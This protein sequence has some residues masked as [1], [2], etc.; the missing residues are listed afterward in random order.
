PGNKY[1]KGATMLHMIRKIFDNDER[2][3][4]MLHA[5]SA[6][7]YHKTVTGAQVE[8]HISMHAGRDLSKVFDQYLRDTTLPELQ[9]RIVGQVLYFR[10]SSSIKNFD[11]PVK[12]TVGI[13]N[14]QFI[15]PGPLWATANL[16]YMDP[17][18]FKVD[19]DFY[20][21]VREMKTVK[22]MKEALKKQ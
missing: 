6:D 13:N 19:P 22:E 8:R 16:S 3:R 12:V 7:Y 20:I 9:Y 4:M 18:Y 17:K 5:L 21:K 15:Y 10:W 1:Y 11:M 2:F 14:Y